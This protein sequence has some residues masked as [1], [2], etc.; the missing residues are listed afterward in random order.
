[1]VQAGRWCPAARRRASMAA[2]AAG[3][4]TSGPLAA[5]EPSCGG[6]AKFGAPCSAPRRL[7]FLPSGEA[8][9]TTSGPSVLQ[10]QPCTGMGQTG[11]QERAERRTSVASPEAVPT[12]F[13]PL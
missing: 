7:I 2:G 8:D 5:A 1:M 9:P 6:M 3:P 12:M 10:E 13:G 4:T 11:Y